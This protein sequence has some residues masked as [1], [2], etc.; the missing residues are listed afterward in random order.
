MKKYLCY[1][2]KYLQG[3]KGPWCQEPDCPD[4]DCS[5]HGFCVAGRCVCRRGWLGA[6]CAAVDPAARACADTEA[7]SELRQPEPQCSLE[8]GQHGRCQNMR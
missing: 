8:C 1:Y 3:Y 6:E 7:E 4:P 5:G 2:E